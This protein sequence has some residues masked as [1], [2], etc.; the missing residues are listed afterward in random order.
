MWGVGGRVCWELQEK[1]ES[2][3]IFSVVIVV[4][5]RQGLIFIKSLQI[6][7]Q[8]G[9]AGK[10]LLGFAGG[11]PLDDLNLMQK[12]IEEGWSAGR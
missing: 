3:L 12:Q 4:I 7:E 9:V 8:K 2:G 1:N 5:F 11:I 6:K 10:Q